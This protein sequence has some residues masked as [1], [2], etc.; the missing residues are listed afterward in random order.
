MHILQR[1]IQNNS[2]KEV[3][4]YTFLHSAGKNNAIKKGKWPKRFEMPSSVFHYGIGL[5]WKST[6]REGCVGVLG[7][8][9]KFLRG[10]KFWQE[11]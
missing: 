3:S 8:A 10:H 6:E 11:R 9:L 4:I 1:N 5:C 7:R 2:K